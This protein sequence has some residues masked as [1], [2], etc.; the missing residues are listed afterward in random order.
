MPVRRVR[1]IATGALLLAVLA[2]LVALRLDRDEPRN[3]LWVTVP[4]ATNAIAG[5]EIRAAGRRVGRIA[6]ADPVRGGR[7]VRLR[8]QI[9]DEAWPIAAGSRIDLRWGG[10]ISIV[11]R[12]LALTRARGGRPLPQ[13]G[14]FPARDFHVPV[15]LDQLV[16]SFPAGV[17]RDLKQFL[18]EG[19][20]TAAKGQEGLKR[21]LDR[22]PAAVDRVA[23]LMEDLDRD[24]SGLRTL[25]RTTDGVVDAVHRADPGIERLVSGAATTLDALGDEASDLERTLARMPATLA[26]ARGTLG[27]A[28]ATLRAAVAVTDRIAPGVSEVRR[29]TRPLDRVL[30]TVADVGPDVRRTVATLRTAAPDLTG[31]LDR[32]RALLPQVES[33]GRQAVRQ[34]RCIRPYTP[35]IVAFF[36][37]W[38]GFLANSDGKDKYLRATVQNLLPAET[39]IDTRDSAQAAEMHPGLAYAFPQ[40]PG[41]SADQPW[42]LPEC[43]I[44]PEVM[45]PKKDPESRLRNPLSNLQNVPDMR[46]GR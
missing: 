30:G 37:N 12:Y 9:E 28:D 1:R 18:D 39:N 8:L 34:L 2:V 23:G 15:E 5:Q 31:L 26:G 40:P 27:R 21:S 14:S 41:L 38:G 44:G 20:T 46:S 4:D 35:D 43:G 32:G 22:A 45:D 10:T 24:P 19:G 29:I 13:G 16:A 11:N 7:A 6:S 42:F 36:T 3:T 17:R 33:I 25:I